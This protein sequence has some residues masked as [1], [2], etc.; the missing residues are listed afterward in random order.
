M[1]LA[2]AC[3]VHVYPATRKHTARHSNVRPRPGPGGYGP[4]TL[5]ETP[6][7]AEA[8][9]ALARVAAPSVGA[10]G[11]LGA[12]PAAALALVNVWAR[13]GAQS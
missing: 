13:A 2:S 4:R 1:P 9:E 6:V 10:G 3:H 12:R 5:A 8:W 7:E 11:V